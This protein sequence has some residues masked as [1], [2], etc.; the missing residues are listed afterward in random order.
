MVCRIVV[1]NQDLPV[2]PGRDA[3]ADETLQRPVE[4]E[5]AVVSAD[6]DGNPAHGASVVLHSLGYDSLPAPTRATSG[7]AAH[8]ISRRTAADGDNAPIG[9]PFC[10]DGEERT[11]SY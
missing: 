3:H 6:N 11:S 4:Q 1:Y 7:P 5:A 2:E 10:G 9:A 8:E